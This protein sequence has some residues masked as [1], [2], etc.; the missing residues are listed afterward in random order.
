MD[1]LSPE[2]ELPDLKNEIGIFRGRQR[3]WPISDMSTLT[4]RSSRY[5]RQLLRIIPNTFFSHIGAMDS[6]SP[7][8]ELPHLKNEI[9]IF[10][11]RQR[12]D[13]PKMIPKTPN[14]LP[15]TQTDPQMML[16]PLRGV[17]LSF[18]ESF[19]KN[20]FG[21]SGFVIFRFEGPRTGSLEVQ[22]HFQRLKINNFSKLSQLI[23][24][25]QVGKKPNCKGV[26]SSPGAEPG[27]S[28]STPC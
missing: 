2:E 19:E 13:N 8:E 3:F 14:R 15:K 20:T 5:K 27:V 22:T 4:L 1:S 26:T 12:F 28:Q 11:G 18:P 23:G 17:A 9:G 21:K 10:R 25:T 24:M 16:S 7:E 6:L